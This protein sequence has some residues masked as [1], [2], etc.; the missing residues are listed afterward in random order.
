MSAADPRP[1]HWR[2]IALS[3]AFAAA[4]GL[5]ACNRAATAAAGGG[6]TGL[7]EDGYSMGNPA[8]KVTVIEFGSLTCPHCAHWEDETWPAFK[9]K[10]VDTGKVHY[11]FKEVMIHPQLDAAAALLARCVPQDKYYPTVQAV[12]RAQPQIFEGDTRGALLHVA[13]SEGMTEQQFTTC[14]SDTKGLQNV[15]AR[16][17]AIDQTYHVNST[18]TFII[19]GK[20]YDSGDMPISA[21]SQAIDPLLAK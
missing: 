21:M 6:G 12:F 11:V 20:V 10:Y 14:L 13:E 8:A 5:G 4:L 3:L 2:P 16:Q 7:S 9:A 17:K 19:N 15:A 1:S 18:P